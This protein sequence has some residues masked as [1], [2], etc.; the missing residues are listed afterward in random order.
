MSLFD[1]AARPKGVE[2]PT[3]EDLLHEDNQ[4]GGGAWGDDMLNGAGCWRFGSR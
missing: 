3:S 1:G 4:L 2:S